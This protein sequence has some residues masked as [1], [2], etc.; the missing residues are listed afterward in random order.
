MLNT[1]SVLSMDQGKIYKS[2]AGVGAD[3][4]SDDD[5]LAAARQSGRSW[6]AAL[7]GQLFRGVGTGVVSASHVALR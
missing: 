4:R 2:V 7:W 5:V 6:S 1:L 3:D